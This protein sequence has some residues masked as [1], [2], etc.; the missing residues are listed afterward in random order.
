MDTNYFDKRIDDHREENEAHHMEIKGDI[1]DLFE[2]ISSI[3]QRQ[4]KLEGKFTILY[5]VAG[6]IITTLLLWLAGLVF[7]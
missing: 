5:A 6:G 4:A 7:L 1:G 2:R 3:E